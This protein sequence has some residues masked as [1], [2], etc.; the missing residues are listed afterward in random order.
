MPLGTGISRAA[1]APPWAG[2]TYTQV[3]VATPPARGARIRDRGAPCRPRGPDRGPTHL[4]LVVLAVDLHEVLLHLH[5]EVLWGEVLHVQEDDEL[6]PVRS[7]LKGKGAC[8]SPRA[9]AQGRRERALVPAGLPRA[10]TADQRLARGV[11]LLPCARGRSP[12][13]P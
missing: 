11:G 7:H 1:T 3:G 4:P 6:V 5:R 2:A 8:G 9:E 10:P 13:N 12:R